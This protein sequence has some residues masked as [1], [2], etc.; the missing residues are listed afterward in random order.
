VRN[1]DA[2]ESE[3][4]DS[5]S[6]QR[7]FT[8]SVHGIPPLRGAFV[9]RKANAQRGEVM[10]KSE[11]DSVSS[12]RGGTT[13]MYPSFFHAVAYRRGL[14]IVLIAALALLASCAQVRATRDAPLPADTAP[15]ALSGFPYYAAT[16]TGDHIDVRSRPDVAAPVVVRLGHKNEN[17]APTTFLIA[18][19]KALPEWYRVLLPIRPNGSTGWVRASD[20]AVVGV[21]YQLVVHLRSFHIDLFDTGRR[22][23]SFRIGVGTQNTPTPSGLYYVKELIQ[24]PDPN[25]LYGRYVLGLSGFSNVLLNWPGGGVLG[26]HGT[27]DESSIGRRVS[28]GCMRMSNTDISRLAGLLPLGTP[29]HIEDN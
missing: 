10:T 8:A 22:D 15:S 29:V 24:P 12:S 1:S 2:T 5:R 11:Q 7:C 17:G 25:T 6:D 21:R 13:T 9:T 28:H 23:G 3:R 26:I 18:D 20:V 16:V 19:G 14:L 4:N 27:N